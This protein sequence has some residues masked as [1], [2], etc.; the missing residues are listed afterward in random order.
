MLGVGNVAA[1]RD[2]AVA[3]STLDIEEVEGAAVRIGRAVRE[4]GA[5]VTWLPRASVTLPAACARRR[6][7]MSTAGSSKLT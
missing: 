7:S 1:Q 2:R 5:T 4:C 6:R 3:G